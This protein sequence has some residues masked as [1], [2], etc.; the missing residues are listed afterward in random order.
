[1]PLSFY[2]EAL[3]IGRLNITNRESPL[4]VLRVDTRSLRLSDRSVPTAHQ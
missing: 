4:E 2:R 1:M 3:R